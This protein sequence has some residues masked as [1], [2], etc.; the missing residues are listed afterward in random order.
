MPI[1]PSVVSSIQTELGAESL[2]LDRLGVLDPRH[3][4]LAKAESRTVLGYMNEMARFCEYAIDDAG[5]LAAG[6]GAPLAATRTTG[7]GWR[8]ALRAGCAVMAG[9]RAVPSHRDAHA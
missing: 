6:G 2:P 9:A 4:V 7:T 8:S 5:S 1:G 3:V